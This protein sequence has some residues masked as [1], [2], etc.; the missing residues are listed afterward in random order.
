M[1]GSSKFTPWLAVFAQIV[2]LPL[3]EKVASEGGRM[4]GL[5]ELSDWR[6]LI[7]SKF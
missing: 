4:R 1:R 7:V 6:F 5:S 3:R 2:L